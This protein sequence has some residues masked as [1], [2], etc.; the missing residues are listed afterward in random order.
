MNP[1]QDLIEDIFNGRNLHIKLEKIIDLWASF[2][3]PGCF[4]HSIVQSCDLKG[5]IDGF[6]RMVWSPIHLSMNTVG[7]TLF[8]H[9]V[10][11]YTANDII[12]KKSLDICLLLIR[13]HSAYFHTAIT[14]NC[15]MR[16][17]DY[18]QEICLSINRRCE[19]IRCFLWINLLTRFIKFYDLTHK[20]MVPTVYLAMTR[21][22]RTVLDLLN[23]YEEEEYR[24]YIVVILNEFISDINLL[25]FVL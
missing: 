3:V 22:R 4:E 23:S 18:N 6:I 20:K 24:E 8:E 2:V 11:P 10:I 16:L 1:A 17:K 9:T 13:D 25:L 15:L 12:S 14:K 21:L 19:I 7:I 5:M